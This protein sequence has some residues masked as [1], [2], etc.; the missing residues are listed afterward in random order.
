MPLHLLNIPALVGL[1][2]AALAFWWLREVLR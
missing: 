1:A 2:A